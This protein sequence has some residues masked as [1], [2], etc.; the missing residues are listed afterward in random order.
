MEQDK[1]VTETGKEKLRPLML[2][3][4]NLVS[5]GT[6]VSQEVRRLLPE[7]ILKERGEY[8]SRL[9]Q[10]VSDSIENDKKK[11]I[12]VERDNKF[13]CVQCPEESVI[14]PAKFLSNP[15]F[16]NLDGALQIGEGNVIRTQNR[17]YRDMKGRFQMTFPISNSEKIVMTLSSEKAE[18]FGKIMVHMDD[19]SCEIF[20]KYLKELE[21]EPHISKV[22]EA[23]KSFV[24]NKSPLSSVD[25]A[26]VQQLQSN[27]KS[28]QSSD[29]NR[30]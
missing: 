19:K 22:V 1:N 14:T 20:S 2:E 6:D 16:Q 25:N 29:R 27:V 7:D 28:L 11:E 30:G 8:L 5:T 26:N 3:M 24:Q 18:S 10:I 13:Y 9:K 4:F 17:Q 15:E 23:A 12:V 21:K